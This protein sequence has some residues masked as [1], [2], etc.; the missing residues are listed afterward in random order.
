MSSMPSMFPPLLLGT[1]T[2]LLLTVNTLFFAFLLI[3]IIPVKLISP[4]ERLRNLA[5]GFM[6]KVAQTWVTGNT[7]IFRLTQKT[8]WDVE[9][10][11][12]NLNRKGSYLVISNHRSWADILV[13]LT[14]FNRKI[15]FPKFFIKQEL[16]WFPLLGFIWWALDYPVMKR[17]SREYLQR[18]PEKK[19]EDLETTRRA[20]RKF[21]DKPVTL[22]NFVEGTRF[23]RA[24]RDRQSSPFNHL[25]LPKAGGIAFVLSAMGDH[26]SD[27]LDVTLVYPVRDFRFWHMLSGKLPRI[28]I[29]VE[30]IP[31]PKDAPEK[32]YEADVEFRKRFQAWLNQLWQKK[33][34]LIHDMLSK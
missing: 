17:Y 14:V 29:R 9:G 22:L 34:Q 20:C 2:L 24:K 30:R 11:S 13:L 27:I 16:L 23:S 28:G 5:Y 18:Y 7:L 25:L 12:S 32:D 10:L 6:E 31:Y 8:H 19:G 4:S 3:T 21:Q 26:F 33:D 1:L 15:P